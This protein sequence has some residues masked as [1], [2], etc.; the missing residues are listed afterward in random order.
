MS[1]QVA[2]RKARSQDMPA[3]AAIYN[4]WVDEAEWL[5]RIQSHDDVVQFYKD[6]VY[7]QRRT[8]VAGTAAVVTGFATLSEDGYVAAL[9]VRPKYRRLGIGSLLMRN[10]KE[11]LGDVVKLYCFQANIAA[12]NF[13]DNH[14]FKEINRTDGDNEE[15]LPDILLE[16]QAGEDE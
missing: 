7:P 15:K 13:Y 3:C 5:P 16:W 14:G 2:I 9:Y 10:A 12:L 4:D 6:V 8:L 1:Q 11:E